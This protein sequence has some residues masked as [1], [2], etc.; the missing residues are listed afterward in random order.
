MRTVTLLAAGVL[1]AALGHRAAAQQAALEKPT[2]ALAVG[3][4]VSQMNKVAYVVALYK[5]YFKEE[6]LT[7]DSSN[8]SSGTAALQALVGGSAD[9]G[10]LAYEHTLRMQTKG[11]S[12]TCLIVFGRYPGNVLVVRKGLD[13]TVKTVADLKGKTIGVSAPGSSTQNFAAQLMERAGVP[14]KSA[15]YISVGTGSSAVAAMRTG[16]DIDALVNL[17]PAI[18]ELVDHGEATILVDSRTAEGSRAAF[19]GDY[20]ADCLA[21]K[22]DF[23]KAN[24]KTAQAITNAVVHAMQWLKTASIDDIIAVLPKEFYRA[25]EKVYRESLRAN[26]DEFTWDGLITPEA[27]QNVLTSIAVLDPALRSAKIDPA[28][29]YDNALVRAALQRY[30]VAK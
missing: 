11:V 24:P 21:V 13:A 23:L 5:G 16:H 4:S 20:L 1:A 22:T 9:V 26:L 15:T 8:F 18:T 7:V 25:D 30:R 10:E 12:L 6:G 19:G 28:T 27:V 17:D 2:I 3:G 14:W 29:T